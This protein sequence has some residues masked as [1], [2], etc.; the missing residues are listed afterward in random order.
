MSA[1]NIE[2]MFTIAESHGLKVHA[3]DLSTETLL[4]SPQAL[5]AALRKTAARVVVLAQLYG[6][7]SPLDEMADVC[8]RH[9]AVLIEDAAQAF[10]GD[11]HR[12][13]PGADLSLFSFGPI[14]RATALGGAVAV[15]RH[16]EHA[17]AL[18]AILARWPVQ[19]E[20]WLRMRALKIAVL[21][22]SSHPLIY[23]LLIRMILAAGKDADAMIGRAARGFGSGDILPQIRLQPPRS[24]LRLLARRLGQRHEARPR[25]ELP[26]DFGKGFVV[27]GLGAQKHAH[28]LR[29]VLCGDPDDVVARARRQ[30]VDATRGAT[31]LRAYGDP[32]ETPVAH[33][34]MQRVVYWPLG[35]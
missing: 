4:P 28:W 20:R 34:L 26:G 24:L 25:A 5:A 6:A 29:P 21:K 3:L 7:V 18:E 12:G 30:G 32:R 22:A 8:R 15:V 16:R 31:S 11:F 13:D 33:D 9:G 27:P 23:G 17:V 1:V 10:S 2:T 14:K 19:P 35:K